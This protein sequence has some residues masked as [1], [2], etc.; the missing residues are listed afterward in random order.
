MPAEIEST[1]FL[2]VSL[3]VINFIYLFTQFN[4][5]DKQNK[6]EIKKE[7]QIYT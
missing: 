5:T 1:A 7:N 2:V 6:I 4:Y 3:C